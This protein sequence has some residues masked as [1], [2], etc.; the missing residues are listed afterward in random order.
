MLSEV[1][2]WLC[3]NLHLEAAVWPDSLIIF[4]IFGHLEERKI[5]II[6]SKFAK[7]GSKV[8]QILTNYQN[9]AQDFYKFAKEVE[10]RQIWSHC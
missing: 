6:E 5:A 2:Q 10:F 9:I 1:D 4:S 7:L 3:E 8:C